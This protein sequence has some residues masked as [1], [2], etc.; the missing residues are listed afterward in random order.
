MKWRKWHAFFGLIAALP[1]IVTATTGLLLQLRS[2][3]EWIQPSPVGVTL[4]DGKPF[5]RVEEV[6]AKF[7]GEVEALFLRPGKGGFSLRLKNGNEVQLHPQ[8]GEILK[9]SPRRSTLLIKIHEGSW[10]GVFG[11]LGVHFA[12]GLILIFLIVSGIY[13]FPWRKRKKTISA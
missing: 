12:S 10:M 6:L 9:D 2:K 13:I 8:T 4:E 3:V 5:L 1:L 11:S 7:P